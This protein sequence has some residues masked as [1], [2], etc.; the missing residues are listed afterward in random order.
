MKTLLLFTLLLFPLLSFGQDKFAY[1]VSSPYRVIDSPQKYYFSS[2]KTGIVLSVKFV[3][4]DLWMQR[5][6]AKSMKETTRKKISDIPRGFVLENM[7]WF[8][9]RAYCYFSL[10]DRANATEQLYV[11]EIDLETCDF[12]GEARRLIA[13]KGKLTGAPIVRMGLW[14]IGTIDKFSFLLSHDHSKLLIQCRRK[15][16]KRN[17]AVNHDIIGMYV[18]DNE[19]Q[20]LTGNEIKMPYTEQAMDNIDYH[21]NSEGT[22]HILAKVR[23]DG[24]DKNYR[25]I[26]ASKKA[27]YHIEL[28]KIDI[29]A[30]NIKVTKIKTEKYHL[31][32]L[33]LYDGPDN[34]MVCAGFYNKI[35]ALIDWNNADGLFVYR[36]NKDG[37]VQSEN[38]YEI[39]LEIINQYKNALVQQ[40][41]SGKEKNGRAEFQ[42]LELRD[43]IV[44][45]DNS[46]I[47][48][49][50]QYYITQVTI[51]GTTYYTHHYRD[52]LITKID[53]DG[54]LAW[55]KKLPKRQSSRNSRGGLGFKHTTLEG[56]HYLF[57]LDNVKNMELG[58]NQRP[59]RHVDGKGGYLTAYGV[60]DATGDVK[61]IS[62]FDTRSIDGKY[63]VKQFR[64]SRMV[65]ISKDEIIMEVYKGGKEDVMIKVKMK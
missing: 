18:F 8:G 29:P 35:T 17:D 30:G 37:S 22:P 1:S 9:D 44:Q 10:W 5:F 24:S 57:F 52:M 31:K 23:A 46:V 28:L 34:N 58:L 25:G 38:Y 41:N 21:I 59:A 14:G 53:A 47:I 4:R 11:R 65:D 63:V 19:H 45:K 32:D 56:K 16:I 13:I 12:K 49:G 6:D 54:K 7:G 15:P 64:T 55:M 20:Q 27:N 33:Y 60:D 50:E 43:F 61:K 62:V 36:V 51:N 48:I 26:G 2:S 42:N 39:P 40:I 3:G